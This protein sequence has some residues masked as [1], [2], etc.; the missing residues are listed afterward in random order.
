[1][2]ER[3]AHRSSRR[4]HKRI[5]KQ[6]RAIRSNTTIVNGSNDVLRTKK[7][8]KSKSISYPGMEES[9]TH[10]VIQGKEAKFNNRK[11]SKRVVNPFCSEFSSNTL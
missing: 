5:K 10:K 9:I 8:C 2:E 7:T 11:K 4:R 1:M 3:K 6:R